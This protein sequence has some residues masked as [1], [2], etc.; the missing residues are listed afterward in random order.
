MTSNKP[1]SGSNPIPKVSNFLRETAERVEG[2]Q[3]EEKA[4]I[5]SERKGV[6]QGEGSQ[7]N[8]RTVTDPTTGKE[9]VI[10]D[11]NENFLNAAKRNDVV[12]P[13]ANLTDRKDVGDPQVGFSWVPFGARSRFEDN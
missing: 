13:N 3:R 9:V 8:R 2:Q 5:A 1:Y 6:E 10:E 7:G 11:T 4:Q 12:V